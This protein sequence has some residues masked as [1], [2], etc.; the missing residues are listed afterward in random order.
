[1]KRAIAFLLA[2]QSVFASALTLDDVRNDVKDLKEFVAKNEEKN[3][4]LQPE[5]LSAATRDALGG[6][7]MEVAQLKPQDFNSLLLESLE[8]YTKNPGDRAFEFTLWVK[9]I[10]VYLSN[11]FAAQGFNFFQST[12]VGIGYALLLA[13][14]RSPVRWFLLRQAPELAASASRVSVWRAPLLNRLTISEEAK[15]ALSTVGAGLTISYL[16][17]AFDTIAKTHRFDPAPDFYV[18]QAFLGCEIW[19][20]SKENTDV[21]QLEEMVKQIVQLANQNGD[22]INIQVDGERMQSKMEKATHDAQFASVIPNNIACKQIALNNF[23]NKMALKVL[24]LSPKKEPPDEQTPNQPQKPPGTG[25][26]LLNP[27]VKPK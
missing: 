20:A 17:S 13:T 1:M 16:L 22:L 10:R 9:S 26:K 12:S 23:A 24:K 15:I 19:L 25:E 6:V 8:Q 14:A 7:A 3:P 27:E 5:V 2:F 4:Q 11:E 21:K 18:L